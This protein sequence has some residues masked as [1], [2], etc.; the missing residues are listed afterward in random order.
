MMREEPSL[1]RLRLQNVETMDKVQ[2]I[3]CITTVLD[4][5]PAHPLNMQLWYIQVAFFPANCSSQLQPLDLA[6]IHLNLRK[7]RIQKVLYLPI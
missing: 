5:C 4:H 1:E 7:I 2:R 6:I 3:G